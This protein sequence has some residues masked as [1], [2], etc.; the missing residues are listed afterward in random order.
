MSE[1]DIMLSRS[2]IPIFYVIVELLLMNSFLFEFKLSE[3]AIL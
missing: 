2:N 3:L 1:W